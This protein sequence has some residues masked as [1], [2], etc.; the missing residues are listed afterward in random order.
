[1]S[2]KEQKSTLSTRY[3]TSSI[4][5]LHDRIDKNIPVYTLWYM[6]TKTILN[7]KTEKKVKKAAQ[8]AAD[9]IG[10]PLSTVVNAFLRQ[11]AR[12]REVTFS[13]RPMRMSPYL[14]KLVAAARRDLAHGKN[15]SPTF[16]TGKQAVA[17]LHSELHK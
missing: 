14:E 4:G 15:V 2:L 7:V 10:V 8:R 17:Y 5:P 3:G 16:E 12:D 13:S 6:N 11:F 9:E 1:M